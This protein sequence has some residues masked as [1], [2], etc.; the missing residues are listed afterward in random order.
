MLEVI[1]ALN[2]Y[3]ANMV[4]VEYMNDCTHLRLP[5]EQKHR[6][7]K[8]GAKW[9]AKNKTWYFAFDLRYGEL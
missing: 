9:D 3:G 7:Q 2:N 5:F 8:L 1:P 4:V 6:A